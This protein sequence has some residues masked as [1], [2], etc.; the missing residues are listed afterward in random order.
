MISCDY[1]AIVPSYENGKNGTYT[2]S[3]NNEQH[4]H[5]HTTSSFMTNLFIQHELLLPVVKLWSKSFLHSNT[6]LPI[7]LSFSH[8]YI[9][10]KFRS[11]LEPYEGAYGYVLVSAIEKFEEGFILL[12]SGLKLEMLSTPRHITNKLTQATL[13]KIVYGQKI[14]PFENS[15]ST[16]L[17]DFK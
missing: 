1:I 8:I 2:Y 7:T 10:V 13:L 11:P 6:L 4:F 14:R 16:D 15:M 17:F 5:P 9:P 12:T 3:L